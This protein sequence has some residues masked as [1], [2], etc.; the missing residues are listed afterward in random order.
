MAIAALIA[1]HILEALVPFCLKEGI[2][3]VAAGDPGLLLPVGGIFG[4]TAIRYGVLHF[5]RRRNALMSTE[6]AIA[7]RREIYAHILDQG[8]SFFSRFALGDILARATN[9]IEA[10]RTF[11]RSGIHRLVSLIAL[12][13]IAPVL[14]ALQSPLLTGL[15]LVT[16]GILIGI[17]WRLAA[18]I[19]VQSTRVRTSYAS[20]V[21]RVQQNLQGIRTIQAHGQEDREIGNFASIT[22]DYADK[23][24]RLQSLYGLVAATVLVGSAATAL[25]VVG[26]GG[27]LVQNHALSVGSLTAFIFYLAMIMWVVKDCTLPA[28]LLLQASTA[29]RRIF[30]ILDIAPEVVDSAASSHLGPVSGRISLKDVSFRYPAGAQALSDVN[31]SIHPGE[32]VAIVGRIGA[33]K[34]TLLRLIARQVDPD[35]GSITLDGH[36]LREISLTRLRDEVGIVLQDSFLFAASIGENISYD[37]PDRSEEAIRQAAEAAALGRT[38]RDLPD[39]LGTLVGER[40]V[41]LSGGQRQRTS[42]ARGLIRETPVLLLDDCFSALDSETEAYIL[43]ELRRLRSGRTTIFVTHRTASARY[44]DKIITLDQGCL[45]EDAFS[46]SGGVK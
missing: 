8:P 10:V 14:M 3:R 2:N 35:G 33:G 39:G 29:A 24:Y 46:L 21:E 44:A 23:A 11:F 27:A 6:I 12:G 25:I 13:V 16:M 1:V 42:L 41:T 20:I 34:S 43:Q 45:V 36:D 37:D 31:V 19:R 30:E 26:V 18:R 9:D 22:R 17:S 32:F 4:L 38:I 5:G 40:G 15:V 7:L 28:F